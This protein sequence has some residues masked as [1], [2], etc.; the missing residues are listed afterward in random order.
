M[1][2]FTDYYLNFFHGRRSPRG[3]SFLWPVWVWEVLAPNPK[4]QGLNVFQRSILGLIQAGKTDPDLMAEWL[5][6]EKEL[7]LYIIAGQL[8]PNGWLD[9]KMQLSPE[10]EAML[11]EDNDRRNDLATAYLFQDGVSGKLWPRVAGKLSEMDVTGHNRQGFPEFQINR[12]TGWTERPYLISQH[13]GELNKPTMQE[14]R[15]ALRQGNNAIHNTKVRGE[16]EFYQQEFRAD[17]MELLDEQPF[18]AYVM[19]WVLRDQ[20]DVWS[21]SDPLALTATGDFLRE[22]VYRQAQHS[23]VFARTLKSIIGEVPEKET[24]EDM[25]K[26]LSASVDLAQFIEFAKAGTIPNLEPYLG[27]LLRRQQFLEEAQGDGDIRFEDCDDLINQAQKVFECCFKWMLGQ[28]KIPNQQFIQRNWHC[29][30]IRCAIQEI[31]GSF[32]AESDMDDLAS[33]KAGSIFYAATKP[34]PK[35][36]LRPLLAATLFTLP[37]HPT[38]PLL[39]IAIWQR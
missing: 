11:Q 38:H 34:D 18:K 28:W 2:L 3:Q 4:R 6:L 17:E 36:S 22:G 9:H 33:Q 32:L 5:G 24:Y 19:G 29:G 37:A 27:A 20:G 12:E 39:H 7:I 26:R 1:A 8:E 15:T 16:I 14:L 13:S 35:V 21:V 25:V 23:Q 30:D 31:A 10:G